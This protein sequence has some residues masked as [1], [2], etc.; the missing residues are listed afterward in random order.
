MKIKER[1]EQ[2]TQKHLPVVM[3]RNPMVFLLVIGILL[4]GVQRQY[5][6]DMTPI[7]EAVKKKL[8]CDRYSFIGHILG[9]SIDSCFCNSWCF[10]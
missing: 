5:G 7:I 10:G 1:V 6:A 9:T 8:Y 3:K 4:V 2:V